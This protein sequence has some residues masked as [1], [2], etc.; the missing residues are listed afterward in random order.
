MNKNT[1]TI[2][3]DELRREAREILR[4][5]EQER[6]VPDPILRVGEIISMMRRFKAAVVAANAPRGYVAGSEHD[7]QQRAILQSHRLAA[8]GGDDAECGLVCLKERLMSLNCA[9]VLQ[10]QPWWVDD[11]QWEGRVWS[12]LCRWTKR[13]FDL[14]Y[15]KRD[16]NDWPNCIKLPVLQGWINDE[17]EIEWEL[18][19]RM[20]EFLPD[21]EW[22]HVDVEEGILRWGG[23]ERHLPKRTVLIIRCLVEKKGRSVPDDDIAEALDKADLSSGTLRQVFSRLRRS[24]VE[25]DFSDIAAAIVRDKENGQTCLDQTLLLEGLAKLGDSRAPCSSEQHGGLGSDRDRL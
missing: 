6:L 13:G 18:G 5:S 1:V 14:L 11:C 12:P 7:P 20:K 21:G 4:E 9:F 8:L 2:D 23:R 15:E 25:A 17:L 19:I 24:L 10:G 22:P 3:L 16:T